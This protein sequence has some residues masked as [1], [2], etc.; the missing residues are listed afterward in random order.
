M[1]CHVHP[2]T[3]PKFTATAKCEIYKCETC[4]Y[5]NANINTTKEY[6]QISK[7][8][9]DGALK[10]SYTHPGDCVFVD[11]F[12]YYLKRPTIT[13]FVLSYSEQ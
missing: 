5:V 6:N 13:S 8:D 10:A 7:T 11:Y 2:F 1:F 4:E 12:E 9:A 3:S